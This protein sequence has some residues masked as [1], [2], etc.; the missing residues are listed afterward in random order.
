VGRDREGGFQ[1]VFYLLIDTVQIPKHFIV[2]ESQCLKAFSLKPGI[3]P[4]IP[5]IFIMLTT[6]DLNDH[7]PFI[8]YK[9]DNVS[10]DNSLSAKLGTHAFQAKNRPKQFLRLRRIIS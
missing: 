8:T 10:T 7:S 3:P 2:P 5:L 1:D 9:V 6:V 4:D